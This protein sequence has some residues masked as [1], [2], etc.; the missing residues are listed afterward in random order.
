MAVCCF[1]PFECGW[2]ICKQY[3]VPVILL[4]CILIS[5]FLSGLQVLVFQR[6]VPVC[7]LTNTQ[8]SLWWGLVLSILTGRH[9][10]GHRIQGRFPRHLGDRL[11]RSFRT[12]SFRSTT[13]I[14]QVQDTF[15]FYIK[16]V[17]KSSSILEWYPDIY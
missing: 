3:T 1:V 7:D 10:T 5:W 16:N 17:F 9:Q 4:S 6:S 2:W 13:C 15:I 11:C 8:W 14:L 12:S